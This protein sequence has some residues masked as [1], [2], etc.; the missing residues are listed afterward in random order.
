MIKSEAL[1]NLDQYFSVGDGFDA[2]I[3]S[4]SYWFIKK[5]LEDS[6]QLI[7]TLIKILIYLF[8]HYKQDLFKKFNC[9]DN[10]WINL[11]TVYNKIVDEM[12]QEMSEQ[13]YT[14]GIGGKENV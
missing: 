12:K 7:D 8:R 5:R 14:Y 2:E 11:L 9:N 10:N 6:E 3:I 4:E 1:E 13:W